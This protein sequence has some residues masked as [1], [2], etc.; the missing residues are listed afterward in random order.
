MR[1]PLAAE[2]VPPGKEADPFAEPRMAHLVS[3]FVGA[4]RLV[5]G[6]LAVP[7]AGADEEQR[8]G[9]EITVLPKLLELLDLKGATGTMDASR[10]GGCGSPTRPPGWASSCSHS[11]RDWPAS[12]ASNACAR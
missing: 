12:R 7:Q 5:L 4:N 9:N 3:A 8:R 6:Q 1:G 10:P 2:D 11:G